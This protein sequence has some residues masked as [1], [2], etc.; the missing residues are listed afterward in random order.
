MMNNDDTRTFFNPGEIVRVRHN[1][2]ENVPVMYV[3]EKVTKTLKK[4][5]SSTET[6]FVGIRARW[7]DNTGRLQ[8]AIFSSKDLEHIK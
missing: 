5:D 6:L 2:L 4:A 7:F 3:V 1:Q 8:E